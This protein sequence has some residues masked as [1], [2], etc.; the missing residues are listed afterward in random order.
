MESVGVAIQAISAREDQAPGAISKA[1][2]HAART[3]VANVRGTNAGNVI[4]SIDWTKICK[5]NSIFS[6]SHARNGD[7]M[8]GGRFVESY[9]LAA[10]LGKW[11]RR[12]TSFVAI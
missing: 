9:R 4:Q 8:A 5:V 10:L 6:R 12:R 7:V 3:K 1:H 11:Q 2:Q